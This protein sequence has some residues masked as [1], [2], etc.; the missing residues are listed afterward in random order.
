M[1][2]TKTEVTWQDVLAQTRAVNAAPRGQFDLCL[3]WQAQAYKANEHQPESI[4]RARAF[5]NMLE[6]LPLHRYP[7]ERVVGSTAEFYTNTLPAGITKDDY[8]QAASSF[9][10]RG[11]RYFTTGWDHTLADYPTLLSAG[12]D[13]LLTRI[14]A[15]RA[16][17]PAGDLKKQTYLNAMAI[18]VEGFSQFITRYSTQ[19]RADG[20]TVLAEQLEH[21]SHQPPRTLW[22][23]MQ[24]TWLIYIAFG[25][26]GRYAMAL[27]RIDQYLFPFYQRDL[28][29]GLLPDSEALDL[30]C[31]LWAH[32]EEQGTVT[33]I[34]IGGL[35]PEG[36]DATNDL[37][38]ICLEATRLVQSP[39]TNLSA[40]FHDATPEAFYT[41]CV[42]CIRTG[43]GFPA[44]FNDHVLLAGLEEL[45]IPPEVARNYCMVGCIETMFPGQQQAWSDCY[46]NT[47]LVLVQA[48][49]QL[50]KEQERSFPRLQTLF[51]EIFQR[52]LTTF[53]DTISAQA[54]SQPAD[55]YPD[56]FLSV[57]TRDCINRARDINDGG[58]EF[59]RFIGI[60]LMG[61]AT[62][63]D[64]F[65]A[66]KQLVFTEGALTYDELMDALANDFAGQ[67][68]TRQLLINRAPK[69]GNGDAMVD[70]IAAWLVSLCADEVLQHQVPGG[71]RFVGAMAANVVNIPAGK[72]VPATPDGR[73]AGT[74][75]FRCRQPLFRTRYAW[76]HRVSRL[77]GPS[78]LSPRTHRQCH[79]YEI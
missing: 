30:F 4:V 72:A 31:H 9:A 20:D 37:S 21:I 50:H 69:Y 26:Q 47:P 32:I 16:L 24:L 67:E 61:L 73:K 68:R 57:L 15:S 60:A 62:M 78:R 1:N 76:P 5:A 65:A 52:E 11:S 46:F 66:V 14:N 70:E 17:H 71:G 59:P 18:C 64:S 3:Y 6:H 19:C 77:S 36:D 39:H 40:R 12:L 10:E 58:A 74:P 63:A 45:G 42:N 56:P 25:S 41:A 35:T 44:I 48:L 34:C 2:A 33:N 75:A 23:A 55:K 49:Q 28:V 54:T 43:V 7:G 53:C 38:Y 79:Q 22:E 29:T 27:G 8:A 51:L 13:G